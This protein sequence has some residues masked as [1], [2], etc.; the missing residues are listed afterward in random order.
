MV[1]VGKCSFTNWTTS[2]ILSSSYAL[3]S[4]LMSFVISSISAIL[5]WMLIETLLNAMFKSGWEINDEVLKIYFVRSVL[6]F[7][8]A[9]NKALS[10]FGAK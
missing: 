10:N 4:F 6:S 7:S 5:F 8:N 2:S 9:T 1:L 3:S